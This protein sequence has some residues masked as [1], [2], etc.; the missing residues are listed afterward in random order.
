[1]KIKHEFW[2]VPYV[3]HYYHLLNDQKVWGKLL[4]VSYLPTVQNTNK[5]GLK[6]VYFEIYTIQHLEV[7]NG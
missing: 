7:H 6:Y 2:T 4:R 1:M 5:I 3:Y